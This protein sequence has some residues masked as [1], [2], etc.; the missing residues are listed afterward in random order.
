M[1]S[2]RSLKQKVGKAVQQQTTARNGYYI[3]YLFTSG[4][5]LGILIVNLGYD[6]WIGEGSLLGADMI[7][8]LKNS[9]P[10]GNSLLGYVLKQ[11]L[12]VGTGWTISSF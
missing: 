9:I 7:S 4:L 10:D 3:V 6:T 11:R 2:D 5:F 1:R 8:R 12:F